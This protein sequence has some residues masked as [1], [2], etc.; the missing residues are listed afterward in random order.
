MAYNQMN[1]NIVQKNLTPK[2]KSIKNGM[3]FI[4]IGLIAS[5]IPVIGTI[6]TILILIGFL[7]VII[8]YRK[9][10]PLLKRISTFA[11]FLFLLTIVFEII[12]VIYDFSF[13]LGLNNAT[14]VSYAKIISFFDPFIFFV[15]LSYIFLGASLFIILYPAFPGKRSFVLWIIFLITFLIIALEGY[16]QMSTLNT[17]YYQNLNLNNV[18]VFKSVA[19]NIEGS[20]ALF[21]I[22][23]AIMFFIGYAYVRK[24]FFAPNYGNIQYGKVIQG[25]KCPNCG[26][27]NPPQATRCMT[28]GMP[29]QPAFN[30]QGITCPKCGTLNPP[31][32]S[33][34][35]I[36]GYPL[37]NQ[38][39]MPQTM[40][41]Q[42]VQNQMNYNFNQPQFPEQQNQ[43][44][45][46]CPNCGYSNPP[47]AVYCLKCGYK[48]K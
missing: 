9:Y 19:N 46:I 10:S 20:T 39:G 33:N 14:S 42:N 32:V 31:N 21:N 36:C 47:E 12:A 17:M 7:S 48:L 23:W 37:N 26:T 44:S 16:A 15:V 40:Q 35:I 6:L 30:G 24:K 4:A 2:E 11:L 41:T 18:S 22:L 34:C 28:C 29:L 3:I 1:Q 8:G 43:N 45:V 5:A 27:V 38:T 13:I 25:I